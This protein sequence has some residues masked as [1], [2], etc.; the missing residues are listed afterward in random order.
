VGDLLGSDNFADNV[1][2][3]I[4][5]LVDDYIMERGKPEATEVSASTYLVDRLDMLYCA[6]SLKAKYPYAAGSTDP[7]SILIDQ[8]AT[9]SPQ[10]PSLP[11]GNPANR[12]RYAIYLIT[13]TPEFVV[14]K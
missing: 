3:D 10:S 12:V 11:A 13:A 7:R 9:I 5:A 1:Y 14:Q 8:I 4:S 6:G 2:G